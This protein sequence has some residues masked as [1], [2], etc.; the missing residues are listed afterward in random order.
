MKN[1]YNRSHPQAVSLQMQDLMPEEGH[2]KQHQKDEL[3]FLQSLRLI[4]D[5]IL[6]KRHP[7][8]KHDLQQKLNIIGIE[9]LKK[10]P[11]NEKRDFYSRCSVSSSSTQFVDSRTNAASIYFE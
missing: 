4:G 7:N 3:G 10:R 8:E 11:L 5:D 1:I 6:K 2:E 9:E